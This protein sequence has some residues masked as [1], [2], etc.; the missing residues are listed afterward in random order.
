MK[1]ITLKTAQ[2]VTIQYE[3]ASLVERAIG[4]F[5]DILIFLC[6]VYLYLV[7][8]SFD[9]ETTNFFMVFIPI[10]FFIISQI[11]QEYLW[12]GQTIGKRVMNIQ[13]MREDCQEID[14]RSVSIRAAFL[15][16]DLFL[17]W[18]MVAAISIISSSKQMRIG[19]SAAKMMVVKTKQSTHFSLENI[20]NIQSQEQ[21][22]IQYPQIIK[23]REEE[24]LLIRETLNRYLKYKNIAHQKSLNDMV[25]IVENIVGHRKKQM[26]KTDFLK[27]VIRDYVIITR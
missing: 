11:L 20:R 9:Y 6:F 17:S 19:D 4:K 16:V 23:L 2:N 5:I 15:F 18:G 7:L 25:A 27:T 21:I 1:S 13:V 10:V 22:N 12:S 24:I 14:M 8:I 3:L 26:S